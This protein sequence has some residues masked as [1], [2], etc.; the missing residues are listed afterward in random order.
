MSSM[1]SRKIAAACMLMSLIAA[2]AAQAED[3]DT[4]FYA[5]GSV[6]RSRQEFNEFHAQDVAYKAF[7]GWSFN[8]Y[9]AVEGGYVNGGTQSDTIRQ[10]HV[11]I[12]SD[13]IFAAGLAKWPVADVVVPYAKLGWVF[14][15]TTTKLSVGSQRSSETEST[16]D[17]I[18]G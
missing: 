17:F 9:F 8:R 14:Y 15:D 18:F 10:L 13:G 6:G 11:D 7:G 2:G 3:Q 12:S 4:G 16:S 1:N 5:G